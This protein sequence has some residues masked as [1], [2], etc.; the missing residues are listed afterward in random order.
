MVESI[1]NGDIC[2][3]E[4]VARDAV[5]KLLTTP[6]HELDYACLTICKELTKPPHEYAA[7]PPHV[8]VA[9]RMGNASVHDRIS[10]LKSTGTGGVAQNAVHPDEWDNNKHIIDARWYAEQLKRSLLRILTLCSDN[11]PK[12]F[13][14]IEGSV[15][16]T[17]QTGILRAMGTPATL[18]WRKTEYVANSKKRKRKQLTL[19]DVLK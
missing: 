13:E 10:Y 14:S 9:V 8:A 17:G 6:P 2:G 11:A 19:L 1:L 3:G 18:V 16:A 12:V 15:T 7:L 5:Q 4:R